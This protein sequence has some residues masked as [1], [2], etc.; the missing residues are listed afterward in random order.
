MNHKRRGVFSIGFSLP[1]KDNDLKDAA[2]LAALT[3]AGKA[4]GTVRLNPLLGG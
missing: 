1:P 3:D 4:C 2:P